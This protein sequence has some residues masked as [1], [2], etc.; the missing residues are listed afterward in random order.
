LQ[1][2]GPGL[3]YRYG[4]D[5]YAQ[6]DMLKI[7]LFVC[8]ENSCRS[9]MAEGFAKHYGKDKIEVYSA[10]SKPSGKVDEMAIKVMQEKGIDISG[11]SSKG[12]LELPVDKFDIVV[13]MGCKDVC[14]FIPSKEHIEWDIPDPAG[15]PIEFFR[16]VRDKI[17]GKIKGLM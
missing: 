7:I 16:N 4:K 14:P 1:K 17:E 2:L 6:G 10:G 12:F 5:S 3:K 8:V 13:T 11:Q 9:Q 15:K